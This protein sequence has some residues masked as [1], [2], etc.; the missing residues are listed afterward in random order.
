MSSAEPNSMPE[1][2][3]PK[4]GPYILGKTLGEGNFAKVRLGTHVDTGAKVALKIMKKEYVNDMTEQDRSVIHGEIETMQRLSH[5]NILKLIDCDWNATYKKK[6]GKSYSAIILVLELAPMGELFDFIASTGAFDEVVAR[7]YFHHLVEGLSYMHEQGIIHRDLKPENLLMDESFRM[8][9]ADFGVS[10]VVEG[11]E[12]MFTETGTKAY[13]APEIFNNQGYDG[14]KADIWALGIILFTMV[15]A[16][17]PMGQATC[18]DWWYAQLLAGRHRYFWAWHCKQANFSPAFK[19]L[20]NRILF[21]D[22]ARRVSLLQIKQH[23]WYRAQTF[24]AEDLKAVMANRMARKDGL[25]SAD[26]PPNCCPAENDGFDEVLM[27]DAPSAPP[28]FARLHPVVSPSSQCSSFEDAFAFPSSSPLPPAPIQDRSVAVHTSLESDLS[29][30]SLWAS[31]KSAMSSLDTDSVIKA[32]KYKIKA[33][34]ACP[35]GS[36]TLVAQIYAESKAQE[37][38]CV[39]LRKKKGDALHFLCAYHA[40]RARMTH[41]LRPVIIQEKQKEMEE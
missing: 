1:N 38:F 5:A 35:G 8:K 4:Y 10:T 17:P 28:V 16:Y 29:L 13:M 32:E 24:G 41:T 23:P 18:N 30:D 33:T 26:A 31:L 12:L 11:D 9:I 21:P 34:V 36:V 20:I 40:V 15:A 27:R 22:P 19:D 39:E 25:Q 3:Q 6:N 7:T 14:A 37:G 2:P